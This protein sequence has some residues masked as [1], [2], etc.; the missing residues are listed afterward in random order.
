MSAASKRV[1]KVNFARSDDEACDG[2][3]KTGRKHRFE[4]KRMVVE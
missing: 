4:N 2:R 1:V 3:E